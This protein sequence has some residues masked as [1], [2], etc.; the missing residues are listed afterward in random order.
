[1]NIKETIKKALLMN[2]VDE[3]DKI[4]VYNDTNTLIGINLFD[5][6][7]FVLSNFALYQSMNS[8]QIYNFVMQNFKNIFDEFNTQIQM[9]L[10]YIGIDIDINKKEPEEIEL[11]DETEALFQ[12]YLQSKIFSEF[13]K[14]IKK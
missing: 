8:N 2:N 6:M 10:F 5:V 13:E 9:A 14:Y 1:M 3:Q 11:N 12:I 7:L 4:F